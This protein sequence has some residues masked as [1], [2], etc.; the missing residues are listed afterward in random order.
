MSTTEGSVIFGVMVGVGVAAF[1]A[2]ITEDTSMGWRARF[3]AATTG[4]DLHR[5]ISVSVPH[6][7]FAQNNGATACPFVLV[8]QSP[9][10][11]QYVPCSNTDATRHTRFD[12]ASA[13]RVGHPR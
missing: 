2:S 3:N 1:A 9:T 8:S 5:S 11:M 7:P 10:K 6:A 13:S 12:C 4:N